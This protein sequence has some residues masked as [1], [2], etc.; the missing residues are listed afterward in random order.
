M[1]ILHVKTSE[2]FINVV[3][4]AGSVLLWAQ[5]NSDHRVSLYTKDTENRIAMIAGD[6]DSGS[7]DG[8]E[9]YFENTD[10][11]NQILTLSGTMPVFA[12][13]DETGRQYPFDLDEVVYSEENTRIDLSAFMAYRNLTAIEGRWRI[14]FSSGIIGRDGK[15]F[16]PDAIGTLSERAAYNDSP[17]GFAFLDYETGIM[18][19]KVSDLT[20]NW[21]DGI[22]MS[23]A[24]GPVGPK[25][26]K[27]DRGPEGP[28]GGTGSITAVVSVEPPA[29][30]ADG[31]IWIERF[32]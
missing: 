31:T 5:M 2:D 1:Q 30:P 16:A 21:S 25:G 15:N 18:Y 24:P 9:Y 26:E 6:N 14:V 29:N 3:P 13:I 4:P 11:E 17:K 23:G 7:G 32:A 8:R 20:A 12:V 27:G 19:H 10:L 28:Q 22:S